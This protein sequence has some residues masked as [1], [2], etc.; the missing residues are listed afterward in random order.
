MSLGRFNL[1]S[2]FGLLGSNAHCRIPLLGALLLLDCG[3]TFDAGS[4]NSHAATWI[5]FFVCV[6]C[7]MDFLLEAVTGFQMGCSEVAVTPRVFF[8]DLGSWSSVSE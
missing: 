7:A 4:Q 8:S 2:D 6:H 3:L 1:V 5:D